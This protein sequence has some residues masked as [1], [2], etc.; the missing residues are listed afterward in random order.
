MPFAQVKGSELFY[1][2][3]DTEADLSLILIHGSGADQESF[4]W[5]IFSLAGVRVIA[6]DL[7]GHGQSKGPLCPTVDGY[8]EVVEEFVSALGLS[9]VVVGGHSLGGAV[10]LTLCLK[11][12]AWL[13]GA[14]MIG[15]GAR[16]RVNP[17]II[18]GL[19]NDY[20]G[21][22]SMMDGFLF[23]PD[24][25]RELKEQTKE[26]MLAADPAAIVNDFRACD[27]FDVMKRLSEI[28]VPCLAIS[29]EADVLTAPKYGQ[30]LADGIPG[31]KHAIIPGAGHMM[32]AEK[33]GE[34]TRLV[35]DF[36][37]GLSG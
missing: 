32:A 9:R 10:C 37:A 18:E 3:N 22:V 12:P 1:A 25:S 20:A 11:K 34:F 24:A 7:P 29:G 6:I 15:S 2:A 16:L 30:F 13:A 35:G 17:M 26:H 36:L 19:L 21:A 14:V 5:E 31:A 33:P 8:A 4:P 23:G 28:S 27:A